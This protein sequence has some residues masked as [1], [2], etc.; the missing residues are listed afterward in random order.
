MH[1]LV[2]FLMSVANVACD[3]PLHSPLE[4]LVRF[5]IEDLDHLLAY[6]QLV[7]LIMKVCA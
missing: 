3:V 5:I 2:D 4:E 1:V 7:L 6:H